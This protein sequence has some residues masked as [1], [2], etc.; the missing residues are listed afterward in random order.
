MTSKS[1]H[2][3]VKNGTTMEQAIKKYGYNTEKEFLA[4]IKRITNQSKAEFFK[5][6]FRQNSRRSHE[7]KKNEEQVDSKN[8]VE[9]PQQDGMEEQVETAQLPQDEVESQ[10]EGVEPL[11]NG[12]NTLEKLRKDEEEL[13]QKC[14]ELEGRHKGLCQK[15]MNVRE[16]LEDTLNVLKELK[17]LVQV[18]REKVNSLRKEHNTLAEEMSTVMDE[19]EP[20]KELLEEIRAQIKELEKITIFVYENGN[21][22]TENGAIPE[23]E[24]DTVGKVFKELVSLPEAENL[25]I[26]EVRTIATLKILVSTLQGEYRIIFENPNAQAFWKACQ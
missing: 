21:L 1:L 25:K 5:R 24:P 4:A 3:T 11:Q 2:I 26:K 22:E 6:E 14:I 18:N 9:E 10:Q 12:S 16:N 17:R 15:R 20:R 13:S 8:A 23:V 19:L 7:S